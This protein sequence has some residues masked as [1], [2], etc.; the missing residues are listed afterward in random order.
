LLGP[1]VIIADEPT[2]ALD[3]M[4]Q[5]H[6]MRTMR[7]QQEQTGSAL[8]PIGDDIGL[9][10]RFVHR[11]AVMLASVIVEIGSIRQVLARPRHPYTRALIGGIPKPRR[12]GVLGGIP[13]DRGFWP[14]RSSRTD[15]SVR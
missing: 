15:C 1:K 6:L 10:A 13:G 11:L 2:S 8:I 14:G 5:R 7:Q 4:T 12:R 9:M 3:E